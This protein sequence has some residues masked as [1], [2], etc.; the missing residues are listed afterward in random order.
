MTTMEGFKVDTANSGKPIAAV[1]QEPAEQ[2]WCVLPPEEGFI[3]PMIGFRLM[4]RHKTHGW[5]CQMFGAQK[6]LNQMVETL[7]KQQVAETPVR[8][9]SFSE[10]KLGDT[11]PQQLLT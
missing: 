1:V 10:G 6:V 8:S 7:N 3:Q 2:S 9:P 11:L 4:H 5:V